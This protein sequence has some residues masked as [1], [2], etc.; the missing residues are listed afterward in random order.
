MKSVSSRNVLVATGG[1]L[2]VHKRFSRRPG[3][4]LN[5]LCTFNYV[6]CLW[7]YLETW[8]KKLKELFE[9]NSKMHS[10]TK[11]REEWSKAAIN[12]LDLNVPL[13]MKNKRTLSITLREKCPCL[14]FFWS[15]FFLHSDWIRR[16]T[17]Y[18]SVFSPNV[19]KYVSVQK[20]LNT[21]TFRAM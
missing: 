2:N 17:L 6:L 13:Q 18:L 21:D 1:K 14:E 19:R 10:A 4:L 8:R 15:V 12:F 9:K 11:F 20:K 7:V 3:R 5:V 16:D